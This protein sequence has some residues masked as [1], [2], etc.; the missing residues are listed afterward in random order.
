MWR[1]KEQGKDKN[2]HTLLFNKKKVCK[3]AYTAKSMRR[4]NNKKDS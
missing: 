2:T 4:M 3:T 1:K